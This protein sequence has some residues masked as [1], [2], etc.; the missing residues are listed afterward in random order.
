MCDEHLDEIQLSSLLGKCAMQGLFV[1]VTKDE[2]CIRTEKLNNKFFGDSKSCRNLIIDIQGSILTRNVSYCKSITSYLEVYHGLTELSGLE[3]GCA[4]AYDYYG[5]L[6]RILNA[7]KEDGYDTY[8]ICYQEG[9][10]LLHGIYQKDYFYLFSACNLHFFVDGGSEEGFRDNVLKVINATGEV[11]FEGNFFALWYNSRG[12]TVLHARE[13]DSN[14][15]KSCLLGTII[16]NDGKI[17][18]WEKPFD[19]WHYIYSGERNCYVY[20]DM[21]V[22]EHH[23]TRDS[24]KYDTLIVTLSPFGEVKYIYE[25][26]GYLKDFVHGLLIIYDA[27]VHCDPEYNGYGELEQVIEKVTYDSYHIIDVFGNNIASE[28]KRWRGWVVFEREILQPMCYNSIEVAARSKDDP[29]LEG[30]RSNRSLYGVLNAN[31]GEVIVPPIYSDLDLRSLYIQDEEGESKSCHVAIVAVD[32]YYKGNKTTYRGVYVDA[33]LVIPIGLYKDILPVEMGE[34]L[35]FVVEGTDGKKGLC[36][37]DGSKL[38]PCEYCKIETLYGCLRADEKYIDKEGKVL[39]DSSGY[40]L[41]EKKSNKDGGPDLELLFGD[42]VRYSFV[43]LKGG[44]YVFVEISQYN[45]PNVI[46]FDK[47]RIETE[48]H[49]FLCWI[50]SF[51]PNFYLEDSQIEGEIERKKKEWQEEEKERTEAE[52]QARMDEEDIKDAN[53]QFND[54]MDEHDAWGNID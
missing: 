17:R 22:I 35:L 48:E 18:K 14:G 10:V 5:E 19:D 15:A 1:L 47:N 21:L 40:R 8:S 33:N 38:L 2:Y 50:F 16:D 4:C 13:S 3:K 54:M 29:W 39:F 28:G 7:S 51:G 11:V 30:G 6:L 32:N 36:K 9:G 26:D 37:A 42:E 45:T 23:F 41:V 25:G 34:N 44:K 27:D 20:N 46:I 49:R 53:R 12:W 24:N 31:S 52:W 43:Y